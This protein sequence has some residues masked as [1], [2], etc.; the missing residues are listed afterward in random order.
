M[1]AEPELKRCP[2]CGCPAKIRWMN[3]GRAVKVTCLNV[4][5]QIQTPQLSA[6]DAEMVWNTRYEG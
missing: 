6:A 2:C 4:D 1:T 5:C 3:G